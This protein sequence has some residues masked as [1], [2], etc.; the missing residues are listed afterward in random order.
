MLTKVAR[1]MRKQVSVFCRTLPREEEY[2][3]KD[4]ILRSSR[5]VTANIAEG[6][7]RHHHQE[8]TQFCRQARG[9][10]VETLDHLN[11]A[12]DEEFLG[13]EDYDKLRTGVEKAW[14]VLNGYISYLQRCAKQGVPE[15]V[16]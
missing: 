13:A 11:V 7:G 9:S 4:Q 15:T 12:L 1:E 5:S 2:R 6:F 8:N 14:Q 16:S 10:L 3:L